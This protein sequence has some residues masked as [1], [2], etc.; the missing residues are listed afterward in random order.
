MALI[1]NTFY[2]ALAVSILALSIYVALSTRPKDPKQGALVVL[3]FFTVFVLTYYLV[4]F[5]GPYFIR[6][7]PGFTER[8][9]SGVFEGGDYRDITER[10]G[11]VYDGVDPARAAINSGGSDDTIIT[12]V[13]ATPGAVAAA[14]ESAVTIVDILPTLVPTDIPVQTEAAP[15]AVSPPTPVPTANPS[16]ILLLEDLQEYKSVGDMSNGEIV[17][18]QILSLDPAN[19]IALAEQRNISYAREILSSWQGLGIQESGVRSRFAIR[20]TTEAQALLTGFSYRVKSST[21]V[22]GLS[23]EAEAAAIVVQTPGWLYGRQ[24]L[25]ARIH[26]VNLNALDEGGIINL[27]Q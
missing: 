10:I 6:T 23:T 25:L 24:I 1:S 18:N 8:Q 2:T 16:I 21:D 5:A 14:P 7:A 13:T 27:E 20:D 22:I 3:G 19:R 12:V 9:F 15:T 11:D 17:V 26:L 4:Q